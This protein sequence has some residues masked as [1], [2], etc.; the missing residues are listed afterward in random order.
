MKRAEYQKRALTV[1]KLNEIF[2]L[3]SNFPIA[4]IL[5]T[6]VSPIGEETHPYTW[7][8]NQVYGKLEKLG[9]LLEEDYKL[10][11]ND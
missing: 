4:E 3:Y 1:Q 9:A 5:C 2:E 7:D 10:V 6:L 11:E 8:D